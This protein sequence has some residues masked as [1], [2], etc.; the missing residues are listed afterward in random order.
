MA[1]NDQNTELYCVRGQCEKFRG[2][3]TPSWPPRNLNSDSE[4]VQSGDTGQYYAFE[5]SFSRV[6][7]SLIANAIKS[8]SDNSGC[9]QEYVLSSSVSG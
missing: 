6:L 7:I 5:D 4:V 9:R 8:S 2:V 3:E 1:I